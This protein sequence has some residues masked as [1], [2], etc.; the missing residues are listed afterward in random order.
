M[1]YATGS[2]LPFI[3]AH[4]S[5]KIAPLVQAISTSYFCQNADSVF[6]KLTYGQ[7]FSTFSLILPKPSR[8]S[9]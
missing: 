6:T 2:G 8:L 3:I 1:C 7:Q 4:V 9:Q 5:S